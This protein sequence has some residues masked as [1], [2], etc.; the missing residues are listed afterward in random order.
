MLARCQP[1]ERQGVD[2]HCPRAAILQAV[3][4]CTMRKVSLVAVLVIGT[5]IFTLDAF[6]WG[7]DA[8]VYD[9]PV[10]CFDVDYST[11]GKLFVVFQK[12]ELPE[13]PICCVYSDDRGRTWKELWCLEIAD[14]R[15]QK[16][17][18]FVGEYG[19]K[20]TV[21]VFYIDNHD[22]PSMLRV[23]GSESEVTPVDQGQVGR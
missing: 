23:Q 18:A 14:R 6:S 15:L 16:L 10:T 2:V 21:F 1:D 17:K 7:I 3:R 20:E 9:G 12:D 5:L 13:Y 8:L 22:S 4:R 19:G 11:D